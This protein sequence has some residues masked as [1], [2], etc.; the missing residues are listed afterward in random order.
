MSNINNDQN[1]VTIVTVNFNNSKGL[2]NTIKSV[3]NQ[4]YSNY[5]Y[6]IIDGAST[7]SSLAVINSFSNKG[8][9][10][11]SEADEGIYH[12]MNKAIP[13]AKGDWL[14]FMNSGDIFFDRQSLAKAM[15][16]VQQDT[17]VIFSDWVYINSEKYIS[18]SKKTMTVRH[19]SVLYKKHLHE[20][21]GTYVASQYVTISDY[22][23][24]LSIRNRKWVYNN[25]PLS[26]C[27]EL[28]VSSNVSHFY[29][30]ITVDFIFKIISKSSLLLI[31]ILY[32]IYKMLKNIWLY[33]LK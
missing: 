11:I 17:D 29:Q 21:Y 10:Y 27:D 26:K 31:L 3:L 7:D 14:L 19:Q 24:F 32:P 4:T 30:K 1:L 12:A 9:N 2:E 25:N 20:A 23:F 16:N 6:L 15:S 33:I 18:A 5:E 13:L 28:G 8:I 22:I